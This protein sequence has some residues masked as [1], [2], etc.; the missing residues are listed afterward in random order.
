MLANIKAGRARAFFKG[1]STVTLLGLIDFSAS[2]CRAVERCLFGIGPAS[3]AEES[4][5]GMSV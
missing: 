2:G 1:S 4:G 5:R 3:S